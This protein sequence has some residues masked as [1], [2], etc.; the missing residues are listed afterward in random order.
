MKIL[1]LGATGRLGAH[2]LKKLVRD[3]HEVHALVRDRSKVTIQSP[4]LL[5]F[6][7]DPTNMADLRKALAGCEYVIGA[8]NI[9]RSS[10]WPWAPLRTPKTLLSDT[11]RNLVSLMQEVSLKKVVICSVWSLDETPM[12]LKWL[13]EHSNVRFT[14]EDHERAESVLLN[15]SGDWTIVRPTGL[16][17]AQEKAVFVS[18]N[19][20]PK[21]HLTI[22]RIS[23]ANFMIE[24]LT[25]SAYSQQVVTISN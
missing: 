21:P 16:T 13:M 15:S 2:I 20:S 7:G 14:Y 24:Q 6:E 1:L 17:N 12:G 5:V 19:N 4:N 3:N 22:S 23:V 8:L 11:M 18:R 10:D 25:S 9:S